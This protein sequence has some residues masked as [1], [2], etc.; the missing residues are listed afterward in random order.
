MSSEKKKKIKKSKKPTWSDIVQSNISTSTPTN[1]P[2]S[3]S[4]TCPQNSIKQSQSTVQINEDEWNDYYEENECSFTNNSDI[5]YDEYDNSNDNEY[6]K[7]YNDDDEETTTSSYKIN[8]PIRNLGRIYN[9]NKESK[10]I[11]LPNK[12]NYTND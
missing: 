3:S 9:D 10:L 8:L 5:E 11:K 12:I 1:K 6:L 7:E 4:D 2:T